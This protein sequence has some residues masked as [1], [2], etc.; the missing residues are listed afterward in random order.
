MSFH[1]FILKYQVNEIK[2]YKRKMEKGFY[3]R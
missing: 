1:L 2:R 3:N